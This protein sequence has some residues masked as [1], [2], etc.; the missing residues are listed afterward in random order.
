M[1]K[2]KFYNV[3]F[4][5]SLFIENCMVNII[6]I[7]SIW[8]YY[9]L[10][11]A[12]FSKKSGDIS[13][14]SVLV[15]NGKL[16][17]YGWN[18]SIL[19]NDPSAHAEIIALRMGGKFLKNYRLLNVTLYVT[20][21]PCIMCI[22][23]IIHARIYRLVCGAKDNKIGWIT[24]WFKYILNHPMIN[25][26]IFVKTSVLEKLCATKINNFFALKR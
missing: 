18:S 8:M 6:D 22:G 24:L 3:L 20:L 16:I 14:G 7:D 26:K 9:A 1:L 19:Y 21:E 10:I 25:H 5:V 4:I 17:G 13:I 15:L 11:L 23:A 12:D 2:K